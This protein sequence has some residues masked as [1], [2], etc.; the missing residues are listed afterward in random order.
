VKAIIS[1]I[2]FITL[3]AASSDALARRNKNCYRGQRGCRNRVQRPHRRQRP[4]RHGPSVV[5]N[6]PGHYR[7]N[8]HRPQANRYNNNQ[9]R[10]Q[11]RH[12]Y[13]RTV[14]RNYVYNN[15]WLRFQVGLNYA[16]GY[17]V[18]DN[19]PYYIYNG[20]RHRYSHYDRCDYDL[21][22]GAQNRVATRI[23]GLAC[24]QAYDQCANLRDSWNWQARGNRF[25]CSEVYDY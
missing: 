13:F 20:Y 9:R 3:A 21:V 1:L 8:H 18:F 10:Y 15:T 4:Q 14:P 23:Y 19:Y 24:A 22:D 7:Q 6:G 25:F 16:N 17:T 11:H 2:V 5:I 12:D